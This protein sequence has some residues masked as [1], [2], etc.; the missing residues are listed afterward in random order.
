MKCFNSGALTLHV[1]SASEFIGAT[2]MQNRRA[3]RKALEGLFGH[4]LK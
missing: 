4:L 1:A 3:A 2:F